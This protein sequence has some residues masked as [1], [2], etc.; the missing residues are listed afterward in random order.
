MTHKL[1]IKYIIKIKRERISGE[2]KKKRKTISIY[3]EMERSNKYH[4][5]DKAIFA[6][7]CM[8]TLRKSFNH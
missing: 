3:I 1:T 8:F 6:I 7:V 5:E 4:D 2:S